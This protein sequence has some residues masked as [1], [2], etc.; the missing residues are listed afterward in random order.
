MQRFPAMVFKLD[1]LMRRLF[2]FASVLFTALLFVM[3]GS[4]QLQSQINCD[5]SIN[6][7]LP[8]CSGNVY[9]VSVPFY[10]NCTYEWFLEG[11]QQSSTDSSAFIPVKNFSTTLASDTLVSVIITDTLTQESCMSDL[12]ITIHPTF[13]I[14]FNQ[15]QL[16]CSN[17]DNDNGKT[18]SVKATAEGAFPAD[19][20]H[21]FW[22][23]KP[24]QVAPGDS[25]L[26]IGLAA[27]LN[28]QI[29]VIDQYGCIVLDTFK[30][31]A[32]PN[33]VIKIIADPD[34][35]YIQNPF[36]TFQF[37]NLSADSIPVSNF[38][39]NFGDCD[40]YGLPPQPECCFNVETTELMPVHAYTET[41]DYYPYIKVF[42][43][44]GCD[45]NYILYNGD[46]ALP[47]KPV[48]LK[49]YNV[50]T[51]NG[52]DFNQYFVIKEDTEQTEDI[53]S[54]ASNGS[55]D[56]PL[57]LYYEQTQ[58]VIF[59]REGRTVFES[60]NYQND[61]D[62]GGLPDGVYYY[63][64]KCTGAVSEDVYKG[65]VTILGSGTQK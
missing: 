5:I 11:I 39:W 18:A 37:I 20:Y 46:T 22:N 16:T 32:F 47:V 61:W 19:Q 14:N 41:G 17:P 27:Y 64:L 23:V 53:K 63:V 29:S 33:P 51:P 26:A 31:K 49:A 2:Y 42:N 59:N 4:K 10:E 28:Y 62:G 50:I 1:I 34:T 38:V 7:E 3:F 55:G 54:T 12:T 44:Q 36:V 40:C 13:L 65:S 45:T 21:Y 60:N 48:K 15:L 24:L 58:L 56:P 30:T 35:A 43:N 6:S 8:V 57:N 52:D 25:S 9:L